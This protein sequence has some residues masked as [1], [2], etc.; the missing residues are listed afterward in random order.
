MS[1]LF[2]ISAFV[3]LCFLPVLTCPSAFLDCRLFLAPFFALSKFFAAQQFFIRVL[4]VCL[5]CLFFL[6]FL[7]QAM[8]P[9]VLM[10]T[11][12]GIALLTVGSLV[13]FTSLI[14][15]SL[16]SA[17]TFFSH[18]S[19]SSSSFASS[20]SSS[21]RAPFSIS[22]EH[23]SSSLPLPP[24]FHLEEDSASSSTFVDSQHDHPRLRLQ[25]RF[26][27]TGSFAFSAV[28]DTG[29]RPP[30]PYSEEEF[31]SHLHRFPPAH[32]TR[33]NSSSSAW[34]TQIYTEREFISFEPLMTIVTVTTSGSGTS[35]DHLE[36]LHQLALCIVSQTFALWEWVIVDTGSRERIESFV[37]RLRTMQRQVAIPWPHRRI[38]LVHSPSNT[39][40]A[41]ARNAGAKNRSPS[42]RHLVFIADS[43]QFEFT[44]LEK[45][46]MLLEWNAAQYALVNTWA[47]GF[48]PSTA[49]AAAAAA[50]TSS[51]FSSSYPYLWKTGFEIS[52]PKVIDFQVFGCIVVRAT[53]FDIV[54]GFDAAIQH[55]G[56]VDAWELWLRVSEKGF[57]SFTIRDVLVWY[58]VL[59]SHTKNVATQLDHAIRQ[60]FQSKYPRLFERG[61]PHIEPPPFHDFD[62]G[63]FRSSFITPLVP[64]LPPYRKRLVLMIPW[65]VIGGADEFNVRL[66]R[67]LTN[68]DWQ[69][70]V[71]QTLYHEDN[72]W[73]VRMLYDID[74]VWRICDVSLLETSLEAV[75]YN[76]SVQKSLLYCRFE[77]R[78][79]VSVGPS[80]AP[81]FPFHYFY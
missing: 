68:M 45:T 8:K 55:R 72:T 3:W 4:W 14:S 38:K 12:L 43:D 1:V 60:Q 57:G 63:S 69:V 29:P 50:S 22:R 64:S 75:T 37:N 56:N 36:D 19:T 24:A 21:D 80:L 78:S 20:F 26:P 74:D 23:P 76:S 42:S 70:T 32:R 51:S 66:V 30:S 53:V 18:P 54:G 41:A 49:T 46:F 59:P 31:I 9:A 71:I 5:S 65:V 17:S 6:F 67:Q 34:W 2:L 35:S 81:N 40:Y 79:R 15:G 77:F 61:V 48:G 28:A 16:N 13:L 58:Q 11:I 52:D 44:F 62:C 27:A 73:A 7:L 25:Q 47:I 33:S 10:F 39:G